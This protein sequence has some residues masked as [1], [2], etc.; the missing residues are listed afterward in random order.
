MG[1][2]TSRQR[3]YLK[4]LA[5]HLE[6][7]VRVGQSGATPTVIAET[8]RT[9]GTLELIKVRIDA[10]KGASR[11]EIANSIS[12]EIGAS[13]VGTIGKIAILYRPNSEKPKIK[14][15]KDVK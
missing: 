5:H 14:L 6:P 13:L 11:R 8:D 12:E 4:S 2:L 10:D 9:I 1:G 7:T 3:K 15:P